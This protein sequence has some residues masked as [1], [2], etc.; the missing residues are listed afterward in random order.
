[1]GLRESFQAHLATLALPSRRLLVAVSGGPDS[2]ALLDL[3]AGCRA[4]L[5]LNLVVGH[6]DHG[7]HPDSSAVASAVRDLAR[8]YDVPFVQAVLG[9]GVGASE[10]EA[11]VARHAALE[12]LRVEARAGAIVTAHHADDQAETVLMR[13]LAGSGPAGLA[14]MSAVSGRL[15]RPLLPFRRADLA[16]HLQAI[17]TTWWDDPAN[18]ERRHQRAWIR[19]EALPA[20]RERI[21][22]LERRL[23]RVADQARVEV[24]AWDVLLDAWA[25]LDPREEAGRLSVALAPFG[26]MKTPLALG[27]IRALARRWGHPVG[28]VRA[29]RVLRLATTGVSGNRVPLGGAAVAERAFDRLHLL[30]EAEAADERWELA[31]AAG[32]RVSGRWRFVWR[33]AAAP[34]TQHRD[35]CTA[36]FEQ[37]GTALTVRSWR[38]GDRLRP[39]GGRGRR[40]LVRCFQDAR[41]PRTLR[42]AWP[43]VEHAGVVAWVPGVCRSDLL[44]PAPGVE[45]IRVDAELA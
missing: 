39:L 3:L 27:I 10:T 30:L 40:L 6:V 25:G 29:E 44:V 45:A 20:L 37:S 14:A 19:H 8:R 34:A 23:L 2:L 12:S 33:T 15:V 22:D 9:L 32:E 18:Q 42:A 4:E 41:V 43:V 28:R 11:R 17:G 35:A 13:V 36:W 16:R 7:I 5:G 31:G 38:P 1:M 21:P 24:D 26:G